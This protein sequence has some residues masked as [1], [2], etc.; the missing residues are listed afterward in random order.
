MMGKWFKLLT[1]FLLSMSVF[2]SCTEEGK[3][4][5]KMSPEDRA[6]FQE[7]A[8]EYKE[9]ARFIDKSAPIQLTSDP[10]AALGKLYCKTSG[11]FGWFGSLGS[12][13][14]AKCSKQNFIAVCGTQGSSAEVKSYCVIYD[15]EVEE[16]YRVTSETPDDHCEDDK[17]VACD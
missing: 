4:L 3:T 11:V 10:Y 6:E 14:L 7:V 12:A 16:Y 15:P 5:R 1:V 8:D 13:D 17:T 9:V 2:V